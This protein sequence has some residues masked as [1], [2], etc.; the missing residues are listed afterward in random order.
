M[1]TCL[2][3]VVIPI[4]QSSARRSMPIIPMLRR[5]DVFIISTIS[6][7]TSFSIDLD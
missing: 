1:N 7:T 2:E 3:D 6:L 5:S 4:H